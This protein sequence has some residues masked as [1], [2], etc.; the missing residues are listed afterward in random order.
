MLRAASVQVRATWT[1]FDMPRHCWIAGVVVLYRPDVQVCDNINTYV[2]DLDRLYVVDNSDNPDRDLIAP[3]IANP[4]VEYIPNGQ[5]LGIAKALNLAAQKAIESGY[6]FLLTMDQ[7]S[8]ATVGMIAAMLETLARFES[9]ESVGI[10]GPF[11]L[12]AENHK[13]PGADDLEVVPHTMTSGNLLNLAAYRSVGPFL[14]ELFIDF[15]DVEFCYRLRRHGFLV[16]Q[17]NRALLQ[18]NLGNI[19]SAKILHKR[20]RTSNHS[21]LRRY[22]ITRNRFFVWEKYRDLAAVQD[23]IAWDKVSFRG[24][25]RNILLLEKDKLAKIAMIVRGFVDYKRNVFGKYR[26]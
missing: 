22:Y 11:H 2:N 5:N 23:D 26:G 10:V 4:V 1:V 3:I 7:D 15:V 16:L 12:L 13:R 24:E 20:L 21:A 17:A 14:D 18:H 25:I 9:P 8:R 6:E 19:T